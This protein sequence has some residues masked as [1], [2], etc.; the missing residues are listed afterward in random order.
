MKFYSYLVVVVGSILILT[1]SCGYK[2][3]DTEVDI[4][5][6][7]VVALKKLD[8]LYQRYVNGDRN[9]AV[10]CLLSSID[11][12]EGAVCFNNRD[13]TQL[14]SLEYARLAVM[15]HKLGEKGADDAY[16]LCAQY[17][18]LKTFELSNVSPQVA[19]ENVKHCNIEEQTS[20]VEKMDIGIHGRLADYNRTIDG[21]EGSKTK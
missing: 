19:I 2:R 6:N 7:R 17:W 9:T 14:L 15:E 20:L 3:N 10:Q 16:L 4:L 21:H 5:R 18:Q 11:L 12:L 1:A 13:R 8:D